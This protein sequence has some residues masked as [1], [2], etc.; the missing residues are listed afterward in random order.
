MHTIINLL[1]VCVFVVCVWGLVNVVII[2]TFYHYFIRFCMLHNLE[3]LY[4]Y[5]CMYVS[6]CVCV[7]VSSC[8]STQGCVLLLLYIII[9][10]Y[11]IQFHFNP[12]GKSVYT[13]ILCS[14]CYLLV[15]LI[16]LNGTVWVCVCVWFSSHVTHNN[17]PDK[18]II[19]YIIYLCVTFILFASIKQ[20]YYSCTFLSWGVCV[21]V[22]VCVFYAS[23]CPIIH[24]CVCQS[25]MVKVVL[26]N[27]RN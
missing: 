12:C 15:Y 21:C 24:V 7:C 6:V 13:Y 4:N 11:I 18:I 14:I 8:C 5:L 9:V 22:S 25:E 19:V 3:N 17:T 16:F 26:H 2:C 1:C 27:N 23:L 20:K 10:Q